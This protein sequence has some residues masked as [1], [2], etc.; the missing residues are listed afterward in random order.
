[1]PTPIFNT[2]NP[3]EYFLGP[4]EAA[5]TMGSGMASMLASVPYAE[6]NK[7][8]PEQQQAWMAM[9]TYQPRTQVGQDITGLL[10]K[11]GEFAT[12]TLK[13]PPVMPETQALAALSANP[14]AI[15]SQAGR[16]AVAAK[17]AIG[18]LLDQ[19]D[20]AVVPRMS[21]IEHPFLKPSVAFSSN[22]FSGLTGPEKSSM[23]RYLSKLNN[24]IFANREVMREKGVTQMAKTADVTPTI[25][26][27]EDLYREGNPLVAVAG[28]TSR[29]GVQYS[30]I[31]GVP[32][33]MPVDMQGGFQYPII[34]TNLGKKAM[35][36]SLESAAEP[37]Q[38][39]FNK[40]A[41]ETGMAPRG[42]FF[43][44]N[45]KDSP[46]FSTHVAEAVM[47][48]IPALNPSR[49]A[50]EAANAIV[51]EKF[52]D[53]LGFDNPKAMKQIM[54]KK[55]G[56]LRKRIAFA[57]KQKRV[58]DLGFPSYDDIIQAVNHPVLQNANVGD[59]GLSTFLSAPNSQLLK[60]A[61]HNTYNRGIR[62]SDAKSLDVSIPV[63][64]MFPDIWDASSTLLN[65]SGNPLTDAERTGFVKMSH[66]YQMPDQRWLDQIMP[67]YEQEL[68]RQRLAGGLLSQFQ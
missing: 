15:A 22:P 68:Q 32:L 41:Q 46:D 52:P 57:A 10:G 56:N 65:K 21:I 8:T 66:Q 54:D 31:N 29:A 2:L 26:T 14:A 13:L 5:A 17:P 11:V 20:A 12:D 59:S 58:E 3:L 55:S 48:M 28:D 62:G 50:F 34:N 4:V 61:G 45:P 16:A 6:I 36:S 35:W 43:S 67:V 53:F 7:L 27:P 44:M 37:K 63:Q 64:N 38:S 9:H 60:N 1:M 39:H 30:N 25:I 23:T 49:E 47:Q 33:A 40:V 19:I 51:R 24:P 18:G 42:V